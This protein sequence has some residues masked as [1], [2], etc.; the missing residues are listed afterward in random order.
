MP[1]PIRGGGGNFDPKIFAALL[2]AMVIFGLTCYVVGWLKDGIIYKSWKLDDGNMWKSFGC[3]V[4]A[5]IFGLAFV[6]SV[7]ALIYTLL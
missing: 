5:V 7:F 1:M 4:I 2:C 6:I 3:G